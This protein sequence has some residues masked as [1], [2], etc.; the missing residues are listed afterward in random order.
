MTVPGVGDW[1]AEYT[2]VTLLWAGIGGYP[3][4][5]YSNYVGLIQNGL[6]LYYPV[7][8]ELYYQFWPSDSGYTMAAPTGLSLTES[9]N[10]YV[11]A[12]SSSSSACSDTTTTGAWACYGFDDATAGWSESPDS[13]NPLQRTS[14]YWQ[15]ATMEYI[16]EVPQVGGDLSNVYYNW[17]ANGLDKRG[18]TATPVMGIPERE[19]I[20]M[21]STWRSTRQI[22]FSIGRSGT[23]ERGTLLWI[24]CSSSGK[25]GSRASR[26]DLQCS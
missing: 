4:T 12:W 9:D 19:T 7:V 6:Y 16:A 18:I 15:P 13:F 26:L 23:T 10:L 3:T 20:L 24:R 14:G 21:W 5:S 11:W 17:T 2:A 8:A 25:R 1:G 22:T